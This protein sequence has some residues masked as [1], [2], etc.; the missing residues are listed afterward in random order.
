MTELEEL[1]GVLNELREYGS[2]KEVAQLV[3]HDLQGMD[4][5]PVFVR[6]VRTLLSTYTEAFAVVEAAAYD[7]GG[8]SPRAVDGPLLDLF[9]ALRQAKDE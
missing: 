9:A 3:E 2:M 4:A 8:P 7:R 5:D 6:S 1:R